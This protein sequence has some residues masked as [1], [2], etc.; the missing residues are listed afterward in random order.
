MDAT[1]LAIILHY[2]LHRCDVFKDFDPNIIPTP[3][4]Q[5]KI[6]DIMKEVIE[7][8]Q[9]FGDVILIPDIDEKT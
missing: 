6:I 9:D 3:K 8:R 5:D 1:R 2:E 7:R 4:F